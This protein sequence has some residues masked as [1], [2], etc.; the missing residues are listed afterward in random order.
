MKMQ[1]M[2]ISQITKAVNGQLLCGEEESVIRSV[3]TDSRQAGEQMLF[4]PIIG[5]RFDGHDFIDNVW[6]QGT[7]AVLTQKDIIL[8]SEGAVIRVEDTFEA[9]ADLARAYKKQYPVPTVA[10]TG[11]VGKTTTKDMLASVLGKKYRTL[12]TQGNFNNEIGVPLTIFQLEKE[13]QSAVIEMGMSGFG[14]IRKLASIAQPD[15][16][17]ITNIGMSHIEKL[18]SQQGIFEAKMEVAEQFGPHNVLIVNGDDPFLSTIK[19]KGEYQVI[20]YG[21][22][23]P[24]ND[25]VAKDIVSGGLQGIRFTACVDGNEYPVAVQVAGEHNVYNALSAICVGRQFNIPMEDILQGIA[26]FELTAMRMA[27]EEKNGITI[28]NDCYNASPDSVRAA[29]SV[30]AD[31]P[32]QRKVAILGDI[33]EMGG[34]AKKAHQEL[35]KS[36]AEKKIDV[37]ITAGEN[38]FYLAKAAEEAGV[39]VYAFETTEQACSYVK[40]YVKAGDAVL[41]KAS[42]GMRFET[43]YETVSEIK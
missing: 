42:R 18:G 30:L 2:T 41:V 9:L 36:V 35:G 34:F 26:G 23:N 5:E 31:A 24:E 10:V 33:L 19:G 38:A 25:V 43:I 12:K 11:S 8:P 32:G 15:V 17:V 28:I 16:A 22:H 39:T 1:E 37:L 40:K 13:H 7:A 4:V 29:L 21:I 27:V 3:T 14:E 6:G 20:Y